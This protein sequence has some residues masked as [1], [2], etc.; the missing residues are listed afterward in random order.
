MFS[1][2]LNL[3]TL[4][5]SRVYLLLQRPQH[6]LFFSEVVSGYLQ[7]GLCSFTVLGQLTVVNPTICYNLLDVLQEIIPGMADNVEWEITWPNVGE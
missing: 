1:T 5:S 2:I 7:H 3:S 6:F 4:V